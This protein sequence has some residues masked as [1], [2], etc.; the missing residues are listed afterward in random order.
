MKK[1]PQQLDVARLQDQAYLLKWSY[2][3][4]N[5]HR[6]DPQLAIVLGFMV[7]K[8]SINNADNANE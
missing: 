3:L 5:R 1:K 8:L 6:E 4:A 2:L 7:G